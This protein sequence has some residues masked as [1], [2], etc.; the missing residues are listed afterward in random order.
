M[1]LCIIFCFTI[2]IQYNLKISLYFFG[3]S[4][5]FYNLHLILAVYEAV[6]QCKYCRI[7]II[8]LFLHV[9]TFS[10]RTDTF[11]NRHIPE[12]TH[13]RTDTPQFRHTPAHTTTYTNISID[14]PI[15]KKTTADR[16]VS[17]KQLNRLMVTIIS[18]FW[19]FALVRSKT[20][21]RTI[22]YQVYSSAHLNL[23]DK[24]EFI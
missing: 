6:Y 4:K 1:L 17:V 7:P 22:Y 19:Y 9:F 13:S 20:A 24:F 16:R 23:L 5:K 15:H 21:H 3:K 11:Q 10:S 18:R 14:I 8:F 2:K 12:P